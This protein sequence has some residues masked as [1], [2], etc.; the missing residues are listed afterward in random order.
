MLT[1]RALTSSRSTAGEEALDVL[2]RDRPKLAAGE[3]PHDPRA[4]LTSLS[5]A[6]RGEKVPV[7][8]QRRGLGP[9]LEFEVSEPGLDGILEAR[10]IGALSRT[11]KKLLLMRMAENEREV[12]IC[13]PL[14]DLRRPSWA[15]TLSRTRSARA[16]TTRR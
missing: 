12:R 2:G 11:W 8:R 9:L 6:R 14:S 4:S 5:G 1:V 10:H 16:A 7:A 3:R 15:G 13:G